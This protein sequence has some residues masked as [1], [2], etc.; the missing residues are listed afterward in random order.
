M[1]GL[2]S[3]ASSVDKYKEFVRACIMEA[4]DK[5]YLNKESLLLNYIELFTR[6]KFRTFVKK[7]DKSMII[8]PK[9]EKQGDN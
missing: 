3:E 5:S 4:I 7:K 9:K 6:E 1:Y 8:K 2:S